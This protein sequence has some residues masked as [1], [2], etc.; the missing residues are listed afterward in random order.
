[1]REAGE[2]VTTRSYGADGEQ[3]NRR[4]RAIRSYEPAARRSTAD[5][6][7]IVAESGR[8]DERRIGRRLSMRLR[9]RGVL[10]ASRPAR[11][12]FRPARRTRH[13]ASSCC[14]TSRFQRQRV[15]GQVGQQTERQ[16]A[17]RACSRA[18]R[19]TRTR[20]ANACETRSSSSSCNSL[21]LGQ[22]NRNRSNLRRSSTLR[23]A[24]RAERIELLD[25]SHALHAQ[26][27]QV[28]AAILQADDAP[29]PCPGRRTRQRAAGC[30]SR[31]P[32]PARARPSRSAG[33]RPA[34]LRA[35]R[36]SA[37][38]RCAAAASRADTAPGS[39]AGTS[40]TTP[41]N[42]LGVEIRA[43]S[44]PKVSSVASPLNFDGRQL[45]GRVEP[46]FRNQ[47]RI[48]LDVAE[49]PPR[50]PPLRQSRRRTRARNFSTSS[51]THVGRYCCK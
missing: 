22:S 25:D 4:E 1:M 50:W 45:D 19:A 38:R 44:R 29:R 48:E 2:A 47:L 34:R 39:A 31:L 35:F 49:T 7:A 23:L 16:L 11:A 24:E 28:V 6:L 37:L 9:D 18:A 3:V 8:E 51:P 43:R 30:R 26:Q 21:S 12:E 32:N 20:T 15:G 14:F 27:Q 46:D 40:R 10:R 5:R 33:R 36:G 41:E 42:V 13:S 17:R